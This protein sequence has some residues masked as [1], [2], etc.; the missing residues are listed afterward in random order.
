MRGLTS[1]PHS[2]PSP[3]RCKGSLRGSIAVRAAVPLLS[4]RSLWREGGTAL[5]ELA[6]GI[7]IAATPQGRH[8]IQVRRVPSRAVVQGYFEAL[9][10]PFSAER[11]SLDDLH[12][13]PKPRALRRS[14][15]QG[16][17]R[18]QRDGLDLRRLASRRNRLGG[19]LVAGL[20]VEAGVL[21]VGD[22]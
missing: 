14:C 15:D 6:S 20:H 9:N 12:P 16:L 8:G 1:A 10:R 4:C 22:S 19:K 18:H 21:A 2:G 3:T 17:H 11:D 7:A 5:A 13:F